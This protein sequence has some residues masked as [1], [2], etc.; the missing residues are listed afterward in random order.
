MAQQYGV[1]IADPPWAYRNGGNGAASNHYPTMSTAD[2]CDLRIAGAPVRDLAA[3]DAVLLLWCTWPLLPDGLHIVSAWGFE[4]KSGFPWLKLLDPPAIDLFG[5][6]VAVPAYGVGMW[7]RGCSEFVMICKRGN[8][9]P[10]AD[11]FLGLLSERFA[12]SRKPENLYAYAE[13]MAGPY[14]EIFARRTRPG[15]DVFGNQLPEEVDG[16]AKQSTNAGK[17]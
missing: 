15:W 7:A 17:R 6:L 14:L 4:Y 1:I 5:E 8:A 9:R 12:H 13:S 16:G 10:P 3:P 2:I 11:N